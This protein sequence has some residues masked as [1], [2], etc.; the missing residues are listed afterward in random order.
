MIYEK[1]L[2]NR[3]DEVSFLELKDDSEIDINGDVYTGYLPLPIRI[4]TLIDTIAKGNNEELPLD[5][6][7][8]GIVF[9][10]GIGLEIDYEDIYAEMLNSYSD[11]PKKLIFGMA[12]SFFQQEMYSDAAVYLN[13]LIKLKVEDELV[14]FNLANTLENI[15]ITEL[16]DEDRDEYV[17]DI[18]RIYER[19]LNYNNEF[20]LAY[21]KL[22]YIYNAFGQYIKSKITWEKFLHLDSDELRLQEVRNNIDEMMPS[23]LSE[24]AVLAIEQGDYDKALSS[25]IK[26]N[27][28]ARTDRNYF[29]MSTC[30][31]NLN[32]I[33][34]AFESIYKA[35][36]ISPE[37]EYF[38]QLAIIN[39]AIGDIETAIKVLEDAIE[40]Y[41]EDYYIDYNLAT[42][43]YQAGRLNKSLVYFEKANAIKS[44]DELQNIIDMLE[45]EVLNG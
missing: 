22:G 7:I 6:I 27:E 35:I 39:N 34:F 28:G 20:S 17:L 41:G 10:Y 14:L 32:D 25:L 12:M 36:E 42:L 5:N 21:Y 40:E 16:S 1:M 8:D 26:I 19:T 33:E 11:D 29:D 43:L 45:K 3:K 18:M 37:R 44:S 2:L 30:Y 31:L 38:N 9:M 23:Y 4:N 15:D 13:A 24:V